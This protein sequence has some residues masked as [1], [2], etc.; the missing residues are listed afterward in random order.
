MLK[1]PKIICKKRKFK[2]KIDAMLALASARWNG[3]THGNRNEVRVYHC[4][5]CN[6]W[7]LTSKK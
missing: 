3:Q 6:A 1:K 4:P 5:I 2:T 7:H